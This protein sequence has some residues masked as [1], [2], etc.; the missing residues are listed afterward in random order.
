LVCLSDQVL[1][2]FLD[3]TTT[4][5]IEEQGLKFDN[6]PKHIAEIKNIKFAETFTKDRNQG[7]THILVVEL[8]DKASLEVYAKH[9][10]HVQIV[11]GLVKGYVQH[12]GVL[13]MDIEI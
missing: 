7:F 3:T 10:K 9:E 4:D 12:G 6:L 11:T 8:A 1:F 5:H 13:A 2:K